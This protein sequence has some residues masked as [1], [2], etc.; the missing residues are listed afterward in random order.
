MW[1]Q[2]ADGKDAR[3]VTVVPAIPDEDGLRNLDWIE[4]QSPQGRSS[5]PAARVAYVYMPDTGGAGYTNF[6]RY[7][8]SQLDKQG[9]ILDE[10]WNEGGFIAD[11]VV[12]HSGR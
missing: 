11:Y 8:Y 3:D 6:N 9:V 7:F 2:S 10:R 5:S 4:S 12:E 1:A